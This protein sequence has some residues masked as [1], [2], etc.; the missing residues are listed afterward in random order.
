MRVLLVTPV[1]DP[2]PCYLR[3]LGFARELLRRGFEVDVLT[4]FPNYPAGR[5]YQGY[6][7]RVC[8]RETFEGVRIT[9]LP[10]YVSHDA[11]GLRRMLSYLSFAAG[12]AL[13]G[14]FRLP[15]PD[16]IHVVQ[17]PATLCFPAACI[18]RRHRAPVL[19]DV[20][21]L[22]PESV[23][24]SGMVS[25]PGAERLLHALC[26]ATYRSARHIL[27]LSDGVG[28]LIR[29]RGVPAEKITVLNNWCDVRSEEPLGPRDG[30]ADT[31]QLGGTFNII[32][33][34]NFGPLQALGT[35]IEA[36]SRIARR[37]PEVRFVLV[38]DGLE[39]ER[40]KATARSKSVPNVR[41]VSRMSRAEL[42]ELLRF[43]DATLV[44]LQDSPI[45]RVGIPSKLQHSLA[46]GRPI[47]AGLA[48]SAA[49][50]VLRAQ[51]GITFPPESVEGL[52]DAVERLCRRTAAERM[53]MGERGREFYRTELCFEI[54]MGRLEA[55]YRRLAGGAAPGS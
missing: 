52:V 10:H 27:A 33:A 8:Q 5:L 35:V 28:R 19:L 2:E 50:L 46:L 3:G 43:A 9:R 55:L 1:F 22:W 32:Y 54:G 36:A 16:L 6:R 15:R 31:H 39:E 25:L 30:A 44:H 20:Q 51:A 26:H 7:L 49:E 11:S 34:G 18:G 29:E 4:G 21:D 40:L 37:Q 48:G 45:N 47:L 17:G 13:Q 41:F 53:A 12:S 23:M 14:P 42:S 24:A 38:G